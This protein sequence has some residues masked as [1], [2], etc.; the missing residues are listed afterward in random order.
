[1]RREAEQL[2]HA[3]DI[4]TTMTPPNFLTFP[5]R[6]GSASGLKSDQYRE[7]EFPLGAKDPRMLAPLKKEPGLHD[8]VLRRI[9]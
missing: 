1:M 9:A 2:A 6:L 8:E 4:L 3:W 5:D 7:F